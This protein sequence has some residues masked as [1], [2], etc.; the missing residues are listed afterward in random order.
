MTADPPHAYS[1]VTGGGGPTGLVHPF[2]TW[3]PNRKRFVGAAVTRRRFDPEFRAGAVRIVKGTG[4]PVAQVARDL[5]ISPKLAR[6]RREKA[7]L[8]KQHAKVADSGQP[9]QVG[10]SEE[11]QRSEERL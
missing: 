7:E 11:P 4:K 3:R 8:A 5:G 2:V 6:L 1:L 9:C 10:Q